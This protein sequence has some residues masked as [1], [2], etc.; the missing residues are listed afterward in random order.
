LF[1]ANVAKRAKG[2]KGLKTAGCLM[3][4]QTKNSRNS[5]ASRFSR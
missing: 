2:A 3:Q 5:P 1:N 4:A